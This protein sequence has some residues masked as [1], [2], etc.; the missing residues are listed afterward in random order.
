MKLNRIKWPTVLIVAGVIGLVCLLE[1]R[2]VD[3]F[4]RME[5]F[6]A[7]KRMQWLARLGPPI[8]TNL[9]LVPID[10]SSITAVSDGSLGFSYGLYWPRHVYGRVMRELQ[11]RGALAT[12]CDVMF[13]ELRIDHGTLL[14]REGEDDNAVPS[15]DLFARYLNE[16][17]NVILGAERGVV[18]VRL[19]RTNAMALGDISAEKDSDGVLRRAKTFRMYRDWNDVFKKIAKNADYGISLDDARIETNSL[20]FGRDS[21]LGPPVVVNLDQDGNFDA[22][23]FLNRI[24]ADMTRFM[25]PFTETRVWHMGI[26]LAARQ[27]KLDLANPVIEP[28]KGRITLRGPGGD[29]PGHSDRPRWIFYNCLAGRL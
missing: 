2:P 4:V 11:L 25:K 1:F 6:T 17:G 18:P 12:A 27:L 15:D 29:Y 20:I 10:D 8:A 5:N 22:T 21:R 26:V 19:F 24:P 28:D 14:V 7:D 9:V 16:A 23:E 13:G 3:F